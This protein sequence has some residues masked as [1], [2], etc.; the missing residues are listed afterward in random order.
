M[1]QPIALVT[2]GAVRIGAAIVKELLH[3][4]CLVLLQYYSSDTEAKAIQKEHGDSVRLFQADLSD[5]R[6][7]LE[8]ISSVKSAFPRLDYLVNNAG[9]IRTEEL[10]AISESSFEQMMQINAHAP[11]LLLQGL[12]DCLEKGIGSVVNIVDNCSDSRPWQRHSS[13]AASKA[14]LLSMTRSLAV[15]LA[16]TIRINAVGPGTIHC[17]SK[18]PLD[19]VRADLLSKIPMERWGR[20]EEVAESVYF[21]LSGPRYITGQVLYVDGGWSIKA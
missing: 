15:E 2:G 20:P 16:P 21:L 19:T 4:G 6:S 3:Q 18:D 7:V 12:Q 8:L 11:L 13:Y 1:S 10:S 17:G 14:A 5:S 9:I